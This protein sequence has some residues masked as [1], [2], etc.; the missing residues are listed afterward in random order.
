MPTTRR[1]RM[2]QIYRRV[3]ILCPTLPAK[4]SKNIDPARLDPSTFLGWLV[5]SE[6]VTDRVS[7]CCCIACCECAVPVHG[8]FPTISC[9]CAVRGVTRGPQVLSE[10]WQTHPSHTLNSEST[11]H[12]YTKHHCLF[13][14]L[15][16]CP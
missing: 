9:P 3:H 15:L 6:D 2:V 4:I 13:V 10:S 7:W 1:T 8:Q 5:K 14:F 11:R 12:S 16:S